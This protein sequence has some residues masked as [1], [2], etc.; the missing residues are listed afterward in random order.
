MWK[1]QEKIFIQL[2]KQQYTFYIHT[3][4]SCKRE[5]GKRGE[6]DE[7]K[8][9]APID[10]EHMEEIEAGTDIQHVISFDRPAHPST[11]WLGDLRGWGYY[12]ISTHPLT[13]ALSVPLC[14]PFFFSHSHHLPLTSPALSLQLGH[15][16]VVSHPV[17][18]HRHWDG[19]KPAW[20]KESRG[21]INI[22]QLPTRKHTHTHIKR[23]QT[24]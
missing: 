14:L 10:Y 16:F 1:S 7:G 18:L 21:S 2:P 12:K 13:S 20:C 15:V 4:Q 5:G 8:K 6:S 24:F 23:L 19:P 3:E 17:V 11:F 22:T 9:G